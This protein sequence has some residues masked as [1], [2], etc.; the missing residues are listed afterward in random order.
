MTK[1]WKAVVTAAAIRSAG[2]AGAQTEAPAAKA[3]E[4]K[5]PDRLEAEQ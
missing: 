4:V 5:K 2:A 3:A 1:L